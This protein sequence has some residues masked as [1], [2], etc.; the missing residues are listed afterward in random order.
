MNSIH[1]YIQ[2]PD[3]SHLHIFISKPINQSKSEIIIFVHGFL[4]DA[5][6]NHRMFL[7][8][9][10]QLNHAGFT[11]VLYDQKGC[12][13][14]DGDYAEVRLNSLR[15][16]LCTVT[17]WVKHNLGNKIGYI[18]QSVGSAL[19]ISMQQ[20]TKPQFIIAINPAPIRAYIR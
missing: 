19:I 11:C 15:E 3:G 8:I 6:E 17:E 5:L 14:S 20:I 18:G 9:A 12:G 1:T 4:G 13:Y 7:R 10:N 16:D 2:R